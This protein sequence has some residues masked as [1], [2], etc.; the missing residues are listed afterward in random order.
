MGKFVKQN[1]WIHLTTSCSTS[2][3]VFGSSNITYKQALETITF[4]NGSPL[5]NWLNNYGT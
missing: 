4:A 5:A 3:I 2:N 1:I